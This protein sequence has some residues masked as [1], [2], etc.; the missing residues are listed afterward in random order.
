MNHHTLTCINKLVNAP[1]CT[2]ANAME[3]K[4]QDSFSINEKKVVEIKLIRVGLWVL[5]ES[6]GV[7]T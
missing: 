3:G 2:L 6:E 4:T 1:C 7:L 5:I